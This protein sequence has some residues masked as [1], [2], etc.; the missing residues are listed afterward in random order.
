M[1]CLSPLLGFIM[2]IGTTIAMITLAL[3]VVKPTIEKNRAINLIN[4]ASSNFDLINSVIKEVAL[5]AQN[6]KRTISLS[7]SD[8]YYFLDREKNTLIY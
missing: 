5:E 1:K 8:G 7:V 3:T 6:S 4:E 2:I